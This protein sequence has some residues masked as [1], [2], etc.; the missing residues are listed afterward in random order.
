MN[1]LLDCLQGELLIKLMGYILM[2]NGDIL[3]ETNCF[4][5]SL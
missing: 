4:S 1:T 2:E 3:T 5:S